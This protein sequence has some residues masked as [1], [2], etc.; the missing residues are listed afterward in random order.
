MMTLVAISRRQQAI[1]TCAR[2]RVS[3]RT[4]IEARVVHHAYGTIPMSDAILGG[5][6]V[7]AAEPGTSTHPPA[8][9]DTAQV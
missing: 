4:G 5:L 2:R 1:S 3:A 6:V 8:T 7:S 9:T